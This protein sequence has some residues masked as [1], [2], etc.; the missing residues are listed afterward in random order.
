MKKRA[1]WCNYGCGRKIKMLMRDDK[2]HD[3]IYICYG[4][5]KL[6]RKTSKGNERPFTFVEIKNEGVDR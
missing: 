3:V 5:K 6:F 2:R 1:Y 4:C